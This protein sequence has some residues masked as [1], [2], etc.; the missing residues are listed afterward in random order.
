MSQ[1]A[2]GSGIAYAA[3]GDAWQGATQGAFGGALG[4]F[5]RG[6]FMNRFA[7]VCSL[8]ARR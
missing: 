7:Q 5:T 8:L 3:G 6:F 4:G 1:V 2:L